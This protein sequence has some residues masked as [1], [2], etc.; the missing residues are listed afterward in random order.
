[1]TLKIG[2]FS[3]PDY[4][5]RQS[6]PIRDYGYDFMLTSFN[7]IGEVEAGYVF[8]HLKAT[9]DLPLLADGKTISWPIG[10]RDHLLW[11]GEACPVI[12][13]V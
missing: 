1:M 10:R 13:M 5:I 4:R 7:A 2:N 8:F 11:L 9:D 12:L 3:P 6:K